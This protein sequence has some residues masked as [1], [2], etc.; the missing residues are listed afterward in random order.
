MAAERRKD[1]DLSGDRP[2]RM[3]RSAARPREDSAKP[4]ATSRPARRTYG[5]TRSEAG[6][7]TDPFDLQRFV[8]AQAPGYPRVVAELRH[9]PKQ[10]HW[11]WFV[12]P[13]LAGL[14]HSPIAR[15]FAVSS[16][17]EAVAYRGHGVLAPRL[18]A[19]TALGSAGEARTAPVIIDG[20]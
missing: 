1:A 4:A 16:R 18:A 20:A 17:A 10:S 15:R 5:P 12:F 6:T 7:M 19:G 3:V 14:G 13:P 9:G 11:M 2:R 8:D